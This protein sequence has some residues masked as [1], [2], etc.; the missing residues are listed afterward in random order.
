MPGLLRLA[1]LYGVATAT[2]MARRAAARLCVVMIIGLL[3]VVGVGFLTASGFLALM[4]TIGAV[5]GAAIIGAGY[6]LAA[7][8]ALIVARLRR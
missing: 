2:L 8:I 4:G 6:L 3:A 7:A 5:Q 1:A